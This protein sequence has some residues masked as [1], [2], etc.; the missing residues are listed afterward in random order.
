MI[1]SKFLEDIAK[2][3]SKAIPAGV[4][5]LKTDVERNVHAVLKT[6]FGKLDLVTREEFDAQVK[7]LARTR[8]K[9]DKLEK[10]CGET[11]KPAP[12]KKKAEKAKD[13]S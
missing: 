12:K 6:T 2:K 3:I 10:L 7:V 9:L 13:K 11:C 5:E 1:D 4:K 8:A